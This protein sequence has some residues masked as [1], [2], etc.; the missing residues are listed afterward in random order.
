MNC[1]NYIDPKDEAAN[2]D[3]QARF[4]EMERKNQAG[5]NPLPKEPIIIWGALAAPHYENE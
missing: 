5:K 4:S 1:A 3:R 2:N